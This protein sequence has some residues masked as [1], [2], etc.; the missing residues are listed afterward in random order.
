MA[1]KIREI[2]AKSVLTKTG[3]PGYDYCVNPYVGCSHGCRYCYAGFMKRF[4]GHSE[5]WGEFVDIKI[6]AVQV[7]R[8]RLIR[9]RKGITAVGTVTDPYQPV[10]KTYRI[11][12]GCIEALLERQMPVNVL[13]RSPL[14][15]RDMDL[16]R[17][18]EEI[19]IGMSIGTDDEE[20]KNR[21]E[22]SSPSIDSR[23][24]ALKKLHQE[25]ISTYAF[26][27]PMLPMDPKKLLTRMED[28]VDCVL[29]D[30]LNYSNKV[31]GI[32]RRFGL[33]KY[34]E[35]DYFQTTAQTLKDGFERRGV[36][37]TILF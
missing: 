34:L 7:L 6:N 30:R 22:K 19:E 1:V 17:E 20:M 13:T 27:G 37:T 10:E 21:F 26:I 15:L 18:F 2:I 32:Y 36:P 4:T 12:R 3:I 16:F 11:T 9:A 28:T 24:E 31:V 35:T 5:P 33:E 14:C 23:I 29:I 8:K 25:G